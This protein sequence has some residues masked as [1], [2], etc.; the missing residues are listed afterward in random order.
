[1]K[2][3]Y[4]Q[5]DL[6]E[7][8]DPTKV[9]A[10][11]FELQNLMFSYKWVALLTEISIGKD[12]KAF[13]RLKA[14]AECLSKLCSILSPLSGKYRSTTSE[15]WK[16]M[17]TYDPYY[18][19]LEPRSP[20]DLHRVAS[21]YKSR[22]KAILLRFKPILAL[23]KQPAAQLLEEFNTLNEKIVFYFKKEYASEL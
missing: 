22:S 2:T 17:G 9:D 5:L 16:R 13:I 23:G 15:A 6:F 20:W 7:S 19:A 18:A 21:D 11:V 10:C 14:A 12:N 8:S 1:M 4:K 3:K